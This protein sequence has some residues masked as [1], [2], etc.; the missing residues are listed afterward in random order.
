MLILCKRCLDAINSRGE[1]LFYRHLESEVETNEDD[2]C[3][4]TDDCDCT[5]QEEVE[6]FISIYSEMYK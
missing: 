4:H 3:I 5:N 6:K 1:N 2:F